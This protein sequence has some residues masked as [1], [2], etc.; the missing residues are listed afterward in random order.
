MSNSKVEL[1]RTC[2]HGG[3]KDSKSSGKVDSDKKRTRLKL[4]ESDLLPIPKKKFR[5]S[6]K[7]DVSEVA[8]Q[9]SKVK[10]WVGEKTRLESFEHVKK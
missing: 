8:S 2:V 6:G 10:R 1:L 3:A 5:V 4:I 9:G 7:S